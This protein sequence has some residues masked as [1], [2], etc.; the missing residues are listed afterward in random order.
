MHLSNAIIGT[1]Q[2]HEFID[3]I[4]NGGININRCANIRGSVINPDVDGRMTIEIIFDFIPSGQSSN[5]MRVRVFFDPSS[6]SVEI[7][8][9][10]RPW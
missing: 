5:D 2:N 10:E 6:Q 4:R 3:V 8:S 7:H 9:I 1:V